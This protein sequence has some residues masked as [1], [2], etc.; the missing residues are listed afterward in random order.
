MEALC[1]AT[2][3]ALRI[4]R[5]RIEITVVDETPQ[6]PNK[7]EVTSY[8]FH[9]NQ[10]GEQDVMVRTTVGPQRRVKRAML[11]TGGQTPPK[12]FWRKAL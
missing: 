6:D 2:R 8:G 10:R 7:W 3:Q 9:P 12:R 5:P 1:A 11:Q 4:E